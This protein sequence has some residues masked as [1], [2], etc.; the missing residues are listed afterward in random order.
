MDFFG[1]NK[2][3]E[4]F[5][6]RSLRGGIVSVGSRIVSACVQVAS[7]IVLARLLSPL[8]YGLVSMVSA[9]LGIGPLLIDLGTR[10]AVIQQKHIT[11]EEVSSLFWITFGVGCGS[12]VLGMLSGPL[13]ADFYGQPRLAPVA[14]VF[15]LSFVALALSYQHQALLRRAMM[16]QELAAIDIAATVIS[17]AVA[18]TMAVAGF[19]YWA[20]AV[21]PLVGNVVTA[22][23]VW[24]KCRWVPGHPRI[25]P[26]VKEM[27]KFGFHWIG[28]TGTN[29]VGNFADRVAIGR[30]AGPLDLGFYQKACLVYENSL[31][32][33]TTPLH[34]VA[35][36]GLS[37]LRHDPEALWQS[38]SK[39]LSTVAFVA[40]PAFGILAVTSRDIIVVLLGDKWTGASILVGIFAL[41]GIPEVV[42]RTCGWL[43]NAAGRA[44]RFMR[45]GIVASV[46]QILALLAGL[47]FGVQGIAW[48]L[49]ILAY[50]LF[51]PAIAYAG[52]PFGIG[53]WKVVRVVGPQT[54]GALAGVGVGLLLRATVLGH[55]QMIIR[56]LTLIVAYL[57]VYACTVL[58]IF[59]T[60]TPL[61]V[62]RSLIRAWAG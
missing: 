50:V 23:G 10:D 41:S 18:I 31:D 55:T 2:P 39:A 9:I 59:R 57:T 53:V 22:I 43:H 38:W 36:S 11:A 58:G 49:V 37:K 45:W 27:L 32:L 47:P 7:V 8:D 52:Q 26:G 33:V 5:R 16:Y 61:A 46:A 1:E 17:T 48:A 28:Y 3:Q 51:L 6:R 14:F 44:D 24:W 20:L 56:V 35:M 29:F 21:R 15:S 13:I 19:A 4:D 60:R 25:T 54:I 12:A 42:W 34:S 62:G 40:M 30:I